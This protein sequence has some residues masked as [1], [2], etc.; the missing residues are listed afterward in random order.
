MTLPPPLLYVYRRYFPV[1]SRIKA[2]PALPVAR[3][4]ASVQRGDKRITIRPVGVYIVGAVV[5]LKVIDV[6]VRS[7]GKA[8]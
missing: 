6:D 8:P 4:Q 7:R 3:S 5:I 1:A 2:R